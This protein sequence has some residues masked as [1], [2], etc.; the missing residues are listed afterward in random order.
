MCLPR[1]S[2]N[3]TRSTLMMW[4]PKGVS[5]TSLTFP[6]KSSKAA[7]SNSSTKAPRRNHPRSPPASAE[8]GSSECSTASSA[9]SSPARA[10][11]KSPSI[12]ARASA[13]AE[14]EG[15]TLSTSCLNATV[16]GRCCRSARPDSKRSRASSSVTSMAPSP[17][18]R[19]T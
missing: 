15:D 1:R 2:A 14:S 18:Y 16:A 5:T 6:S 7:S 3:L 17:P 9:K 8:P 19:W 11:S 12:R 13:T 4:K 10:R